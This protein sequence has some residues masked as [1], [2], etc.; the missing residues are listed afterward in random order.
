MLL[1]G[2]GIESVLDLPSR[3]IDA[4][5]A[6]NLPIKHYMGGAFDRDEATKLQARF[7][8]A[9]RSFY[10]LDI[11]L[12]PLPKVDLIICWDH[13]SPLPPIEVESALLQCKKSGSKFLML[14]HYPAVEVNPEGESLIARPINWKK[15]PYHLPEPIIAL[16]QK[17][18]GEYLALWNIKDIK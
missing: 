11:R 1:E 8:G 10:P 7:G 4:L 5:K 9:T 17:E 13:L 2:F 6:H 18:E 16:L 15:A 3:D 12:D 14:S